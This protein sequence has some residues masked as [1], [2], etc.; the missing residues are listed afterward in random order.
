MGFRTHAAVHPLHNGVVHQHYPHT[1]KLSVLFCTNLYVSQLNPLRSPA[2]AAIEV[3]L[4]PVQISDYP[5]IHTVITQDRTWIDLTTAVGDQ[6]SDLLSIRNPW[7]WRQWDRPIDADLLKM[8]ENITFKSSLN[9]VAHGKAREGKWRG[10]W[11]MEW[12]VSTLHTSSEHGVSG[13]TTADAHISAVSSRLN[14]RPRRF[15][16][17]RP[18]RRKTKSGFCAC[19]ITFETQST[20]VEVRKAD[21]RQPV[22]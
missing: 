8:N 16:W 9:V 11:R 20:S 22:F 21:G 18:F 17:T 12:V 3:Y 7:P 14:W 6:T 2:F 5:N 13:I 1:G 10:N 19:A 4:N 15:K